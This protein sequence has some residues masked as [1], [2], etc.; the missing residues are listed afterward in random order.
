MLKST[1][2]ELRNRLAEMNAEIIQQHE[3]LK[4]LHETRIILQFQLDSLVYPIL[5]LPVE[6]IS[7]IFIHCLPVG[8]AKVTLAHAPFVL[9]KIC[10]RWREIALTTPR[11]WATLDANVVSLRNGL[12]PG[13]SPSSAGW[14]NLA[15]GWLSRAR[16][17]PLSVTLRHPPEEDVECDIFQ[18]DFA[19]IK[20]ISH[21]AR[22]SRNF[23]A[24]QF[25]LLKRLVIGPAVPGKDLE[26]NSLA[27]FADAPKLRELVL[28]G[29]LFIPVSDVSL[30]WKQLTAFSGH[31]FALNDFLIFSVWLRTWNAATFLSGSMG[32]DWPG[33]DVLNFVTLPALHTLNVSQIAG[34]AQH[35]MED[36]FSR[37]SAPL[38]SLTIAPDCEDDFR[39]WEGSLRLMPDLE[40]LQLHCRESIFSGRILGGVRS[41][42]E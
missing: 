5:T 6:I 32:I 42:R 4:K 27:F 36:F 37:S 3:I 24:G 18:P 39:S 26:V 30:P 21:Q 10:R 22:I 33:N 1:A 19:F 12:C 16:H 11:L 17:N 34:L 20:C 15:T 25:P 2:A 40:D 14:I 9:L 29:P 35:E 7:E 8:N 23:T 31:N 28:S 13:S 41:Q 38:R